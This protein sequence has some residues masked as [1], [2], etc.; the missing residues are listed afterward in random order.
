MNNRQ[1]LKIT[2]FSLKID[3]LH[4]VFWGRFILIYFSKIDIKNKFLKHKNMGYDL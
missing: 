1:I 2:M 4:S 3:N